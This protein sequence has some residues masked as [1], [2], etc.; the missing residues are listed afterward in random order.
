MQLSREELLEAYRH[1]LRI[2]FRQSATCTSAL[3]AEPTRIKTRTKRSQH[4]HNEKQLRLFGARATKLQNGSQSN[5]GRFLVVASLTASLVLV[6]V[7]AR[8]ALAQ[9]SSTAALTGTITDF[10]GAMVGSVAIKLTNETTG[11]TR[12]VTSRSDGSFLIP[13]LAPGSY[14]LET[15]MTGFKPTVRSGI[16][17]NVT[18]TATLNIQLEVGS[19]TEH[20]TVSATP[21]LHKAVR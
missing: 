16:R 6:L 4:M 5:R 10:T 13:L 8:I 14:R 17:V 3:V 18:E 12:N 11:E 21:S 20:I 9:T 7:A 19:A 1:M 2:R 15:I